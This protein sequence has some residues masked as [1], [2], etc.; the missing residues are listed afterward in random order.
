[1]RAML[2]AL[3][4]GR[5]IE[6]PDPDKRDSLTL[7]ASLIEAVPGVR[8]DSQVVERILARE[9]QA[10]T[11]MG[12]GIACPHAR[13]AEEGPLLAAIGW[14]PQGVVYD[15]AD[16]ALVRL[17]LLYYIPDAERN[18]YLKEISALARALQSNE[19]FRDVAQA[20]DLNAVRL[21]LLD[22][23]AVGM[24]SSGTE[25]R[26]RMIQIETRIAPAP[27]APDAFDP[28]RVVPAWVIQNA[29]GRL[30]ALS[31]DEET[32]R[33][34]EAQPELGKRL[35]REPSFAVNDWTIVVRESSTYELSR[36]LHDCLVVKPNGP[37][38]T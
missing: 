14:S 21:R 31:H 7:L 18:A 26:A 9:A 20:A 23:V 3:E 16:G 36:Q 10:S 6:L 5:L 38:S 12:Y 17:I 28:K 13:T 15:N 11:Y 19:K 22:L 2:T 29:D 30:L 35:L 25:A 4:E 32:V 1:M 37:P 33:W 8:S 34:L 24:G 27:S